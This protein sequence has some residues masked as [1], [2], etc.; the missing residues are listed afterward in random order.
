MSVPALFGRNYE[1]TIQTPDGEQIEILPP[2]S[3]HFQIIRNT[4]SSP[5]SIKL[6]IYNLSQS[7]RGKLK[8]DKYSF[9]ENWQMQLKAGYGNNLYTV[10][11]G[12]IYEV[13]SLKIGTEWVT[14]IDGF[15]G[16]FAIQNGVTSATFG[17]GTSL[18]DQVKAMASDLPGI[19]VGVITGESG[20]SER[21]SVYMGQTSEALDKATGEQWFIDLGTLHSLGDEQALANLQVVVIDGDILLETPKRRET[22]V[23][24]KVLFLPQCSVKAVCEIRRA[25]R[26]FN[27]QWQILGFTHDVTISSAEAGSATTTIQLYTGPAELVQ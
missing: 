1:L 6:T 27:G 26:I 2:F 25:D 24:C 17:A 10:F 22:F 4:M 14:S 16:M 21:G 8:K 15:D 9:A 20:E 7:T 18:Q 3:I 12:N 5:N 11:L 13:A 19:A 23:D